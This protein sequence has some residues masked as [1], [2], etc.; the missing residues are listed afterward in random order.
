MGF[1]KVA[2]YN[3]EKYG[4]LF[5]LQNDQDYADVIFLYQSADDVLIGDVHYIKSGDYSG[6]VHCAGRG[7]PACAKNIR[8]QTKLFIPLY[9]VTDGEVQFFD[10]SNK[11]EPQLFSDVLS[12]FPNPSEYVFR[13]TRHGVANSVDTKYSIIAVGTNS[14]LP[15]EQ[16]LNTNNIQFPDYYEH[17]CKGVDVSTMNAWLNSANSATSSAYNGG[18]MPSYT[19]TPRAAAAAPV[20]P[21]P[22]VKDLDAIIDECAPFDTESIDEVPEF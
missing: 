17:I 6:Y 16:I 22:S 15:Y 4:G 11:F 8:T 5:R 19:P 7:C 9:N 14:V 21:P 20:A 10:R 2:D 3:K 18:S 13:I 1:K 12:K